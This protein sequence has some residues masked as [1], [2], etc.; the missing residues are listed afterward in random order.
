MTVENDEKAIITTVNSFCPHIRDTCNIDCIYFNRQ[1]VYGNGVHASGKYVDRWYCTYNVGYRAN[2]KVSTYKEQYD[3]ESEA[4]K[5][6]FG[7]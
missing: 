6:L 4:M 2:L 3:L 5:E 1:M 7:G